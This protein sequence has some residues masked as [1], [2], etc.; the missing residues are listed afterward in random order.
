MVGV[1]LSTTRDRNLRRLEHE[2]HDFVF[3]PFDEAAARE[4]GRIYAY[5]RRTGRPIQQIDMQTAAIALTIANCT[6]V[7]ADSDFQAIPG[8]TIEIWA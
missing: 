1:E 2:L 8:L 6:L 7:T 5:L 3:W 4:F